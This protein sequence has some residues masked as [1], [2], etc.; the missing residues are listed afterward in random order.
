M[1][2]LIIILCLGFIIFLPVAG[3]PFVCSVTATPVSFSNYDVF[4]PVPNDSTGTVSVNCNNPDK[5][6]MPVVIGI[7]SGNSGIFTPRQMRQNTGP[8]LMNYN[9]FIDSSRMAVWGDGTAST[10]TVT[11]MVTRNMRLNQI[12]Y[13]RVQALQNLKVGT[14][15]DVLTVTVAW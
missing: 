11:G 10:S 1:K 3:L 6:P 7:S 8:A 15:S 9:L 13:G 12:I 14:Y 2:R 5:N 4:S